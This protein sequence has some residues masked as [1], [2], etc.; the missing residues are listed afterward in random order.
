MMW[1][2]CR[3]T[4]RFLVWWLFALP[5][6]V[7]NIYGWGTPFVSAI[8]TFLLLGV[9]NIGV[10]IEQPFQVLP[11]GPIAQGCVRAVREIFAHHK[12]L[13]LLLLLFQK[14]AC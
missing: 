4:S 14:P 11:M 10:Q 6:S 12:G 13:L 3:H 7:W 8:I 1:V 9:E 2:C 5:F